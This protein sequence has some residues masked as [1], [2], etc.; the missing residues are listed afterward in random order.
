MIGIP[1]H[2]EITQPPNTRVSHDVKDK[3]MRHIKLNRTQLPDIMRKL[4]PIKANAE[5]RD[6]LNH[7]QTDLIRAY[8]IA[9]NWI[10]HGTTGVRFKLS[11]KGPINKSNTMRR[12]ILNPKTGKM[13]YVDGVI[14]KQI[15]QNKKKKRSLKIRL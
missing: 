12:K 5:I 14:G 15:L 3:L 11:G 7:R 1:N 10:G 8:K 9:A 2:P 6:E 13:V 4:R